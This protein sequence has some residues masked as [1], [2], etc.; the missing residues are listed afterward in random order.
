MILAKAATLQARSSLR[1]PNSIVAGKSLQREQLIDHLTR[2][3]YRN[4]E[5]NEPGTFCVAGNALH[6]NARLPEFASAVITFERGRITAI[7][8]DNH[9]ADQVEVEPETLIAFMRMVRD[10]RARRMNLRRIVLPAADLIS[11]PFYDAAR[12]SED[13]NFETSN[14]I[15]ELGMAR[16]GLDWIRSGFKRTASGSGITQ[17]MIK[18]V[19]LKDQEKTAGRKVREIFLALAASR[20][21]SKQEIFAAYANNVYLGHVENG[22]TLFGVEA[23]AQE[24]FGSGIR[25]ITL[26]QVGDPGRYARPAGILSAHGSQR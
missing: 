19:V 2:I 16:S 24:Y 21:M 20:M 12:A 3:G 18:V 25:S 13:K 6:I 15:D 10:E 7:S 17:Q 26:A 4:S 11:S 8:I 14:G 23:A 5:N 1:A 9:P 22:P